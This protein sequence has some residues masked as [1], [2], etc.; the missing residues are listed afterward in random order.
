MDRLAEFITGHVKGSSN[1]GFD[2]ASVKATVVHMLN[3]FQLCVLF[4]LLVWFVTSSWGL[5]S[6]AVSVFLM[7]VIYRVSAVMYTSYR[8]R[9]TSSKPA[10]AAEAA[11]A[12]FR[13]LIN[14]LI[15]HVINNIK[16]VLGPGMSLIGGLTAPQG[17][18]GT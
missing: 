8:C 11:E 13:E 10:E 1:K 15:Q 18:Q 6:L 9:T 7:F 2:R 4:T 3:A 16:V 17:P 14:T 12:E 5:L